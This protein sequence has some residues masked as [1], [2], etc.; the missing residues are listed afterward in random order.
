M[1]IELTFG[2]ISATTG[3]LNFIVEHKTQEAN[4]DLTINRQ[5]RKSSLDNMCN[6][7]PLAPEKECFWWAKK[8]ISMLKGILHDGYYR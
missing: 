7:I 5:D 4:C 3:V 1:I 2:Q 6:S 8:E